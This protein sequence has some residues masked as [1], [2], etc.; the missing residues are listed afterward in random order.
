[1]NQ[2]PPTQY[3]GDFSTA[4]RIFAI[5]IFVTFFVGAVAMGGAQWLNP[6]IADAMA[7]LKTQEARQLQLQNDQTA[8]LADLA[9]TKQ[10]EQ[11]KQDLENRRTFF[12]HL[13]DSVSVLIA[14]LSIFLP[15]GFITLLMGGI[16]KWLG[17]PEVLQHSI[18][19]L[20]TTREY[21]DSRDHGSG[22]GSI[23]NY[24]HSTQ[25]VGRELTRVEK[26][27]HQEE[28]ERARQRERDERRFATRRPNARSWNSGGEVVG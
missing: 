24:A 5:L 27:M 21:G 17:I 14:S 19:A 13:W 18:E 26:Q 3:S 4:F 23:T 22:D 9:A 15:F 12:Q 16:L 10:Q 11:D 25:L 1:M 28:R 6:K 20:A 7:A 2:F 8:K